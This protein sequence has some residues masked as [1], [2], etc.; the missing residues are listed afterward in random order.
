MPFII[1]AYDKPDSGAL[2]AETRDA[3]LAYLAPHAPRILAGG[4][5][6]SDDG[7]SALGSLIILDT[8]ER[9]EAEALAANDP[10][11]LAGLFERVEILRWRKVLFD[12]AVV[13]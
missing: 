6:L 5:L 9:A 2:R 1:R 12:G 7:S 4:A 10:Y 3:H 13:A 8:E 11:A